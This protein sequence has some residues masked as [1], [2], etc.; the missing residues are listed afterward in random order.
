MM[1]S[2]I[3]QDL[4]EEILSRVPTTSLGAVRSTCKQWNALSKDPSFAK[5]HCGK[6]AE[7]ILVIMLN[8]FR[9]QLMSVNLHSNK[10]LVDPS[11]KEIC[12]SFVQVFHCDGLLL[13]V[14][15]ENS[16]SLLVWN[17]YLGQ[18]RWIKPT[19]GK[20]TSN[21]HLV[22]RYALGYDNNRNHKIFRYLNDYDDNARQLIVGFEIFDLKCNIW[23]A[24]DVTPD[25]Y[26]PYSFCGW[27]SVKGN[28]YFVAQ[29][30][31]GG[32]VRTNFLLCFD[33]TKESFGRHLHLPFDFHPEYGVTLSSVREEKLAV[34]FKKW[35]ADDMDIWITTKIEPNAVSWSYFL[36]LDRTVIGIQI[37][38]N[39]FIDEKKKIAV[40]YS[41]DRKESNNFTAYMCGEDGYCYQE[42][43][44]G[45]SGSRPFV[46]PY[47]PSWVQ[48]Q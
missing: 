47:A 1:M 2:D 6:A 22:E 4:L 28:T 16:T 10:D 29:K 12:N 24:L 26:K 36:K 44:L 8:D 32:G 23:K 48:I 46:Y 20:P 14:P 43:H 15:K 7:A 31:L 30:I 25:W 42:V 13:C 27:V 21:S 11:V 5:K 39:F 35:N 34:L 38:V 19:S 45:E 18:T 33:F 17:P 40:I 37:S 41:K 9:A 3:S